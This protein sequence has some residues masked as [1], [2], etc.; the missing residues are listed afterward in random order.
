MGELVID[1]SRA[2]DGRRE[3][4]LRLA[5][6]TERIFIERLDG[7]LPTGSA[8]AFVL[9]AVPVFMHRAEP[10]NV[11]APV[12]RRLLA[13]LDNCQSAWSR[14]NPS[15]YA[16]VGI[17]AE[18]RVEGYP[19]SGRAMCSFTGGVDG[20]YS[21]LRHRSGAAG[22]ATVDLE[23]ALF[24]HG[25]DIPLADGVGFD[26]SRRRS[27]AFLDGLG[28]RSITM[29]TNLRSVLYDWRFEHGAAVA[30]MLTALAPEYGIGLIASTAPYHSSATRWGSNPITDPLLSSGL[31]D[32]RY[33]G[34][35][36]TRV[37]KVGALLTTPGAVSQLRFCWESE[38]HDV[39]C[40]VCSKCVHTACAFLAHG[41]S[42][43]TCFT[44]W[45]TIDE[46]RSIP[47]A[48]AGVLEGLSWVLD[49]A[50][51]QGRADETWYSA[52]REAVD[53]AAPMCS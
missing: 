38:P 37:D 23:A 16:R 10:M 42:D 21:V 6:Q 20:T 52:L 32:I 4:V 33:D 36:A 7:P 45:P 19:T 26:D 50:S 48:T 28:V 12:S 29:R 15:P 40:G 8:D 17:S 2:A 30:A 18:E 31:I 46:I 51:E 44:R 53:R 13:G 34:A 5:G 3:A 14:W 24:V 22:N 1:D 35:E 25:F 11:S 9:A 39:N 49:V 41:V 27:T 47:I 43:A